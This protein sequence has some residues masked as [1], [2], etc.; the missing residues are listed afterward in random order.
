MSLLTF[1]TRCNDPS[2][3]AISSG[4]KPLTLPVENTNELLKIITF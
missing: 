2:P 4:V 1:T 3:K